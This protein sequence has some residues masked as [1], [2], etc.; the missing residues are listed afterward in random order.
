MKSHLPTPQDKEDSILKRDIKGI[1]SLVLM[2]LLLLS[3]WNFDGDPTRRHWLGLAGYALGGLLHA[4]LGVGS[5]MVVFY[6]GW[7]GVSFLS[8]FPYPATVLKRLAFGLFLLSFC[9]IANVIEATFPGLTELFG[10]PYSSSTLRGMIVQNSSHYYL[11]GVVC[12]WVYY[13]APFF[14][15][16]LLLNKLGTLLVFLTT[17]LASVLFLADARVTDVTTWLKEKCRRSP[18]PELAKEPEVLPKNPAS[19]PKE[20]F[21]TPPHVETSSAL[22]E[23]LGIRNE[24]KLKARPVSSEPR[25]KEESSSSQSPLTLPGLQVRLPEPQMQPELLFGHL[26]ME[27]AR[28][29]GETAAVALQEPAKK[30][31]APLKTKP[32]C[33]PP[34]QL[35][36]GDYAHYRLPPLSLL[37]EPTKVDQTLLKKGLKRQADRLEETLL[38]F[39]IEAKVGD[40]HCGPT[41]TSF[42]VHP[43]VGVKVQRIK[44]LEHDIALNLEAR[45]LRLI[46]P[47][48]GKA[49][50]GIEVPNAQPQEVG[51]KDILSSYQKGSQRYRIPVLLGKSVHGDYVMNDLTR[52][53]HCIIAGTTG[54]GKSVCI[55]TIVMTVLMMAKPD[56]IRLLMVDPKK[57]EL[58]AYSSLPHMLAPVITEA[59]EACAALNWLTKEMELRYELL[60]QLGTRNIEAFNNR[61]VDAEREAALSEVLGQKIPARM[62]YFLVIIDELADLMMVSSQDIETPIARLAQMARAVGIHL[63][64]AT[65][66]PSREVITGLIKANFP[67]R[68]SFKVSS[69]INSQIVLDDVG[70]ETLLGNGDMLF[71]PPS[72]SHLIRAQGPYVRDE[73]INQ[74]IRFICAQSPVN[75][76]TTSFVALHLGRSGGEGAAEEA[77]DSLYEEAYEL[78]MNTGNASTTFLQ[79]KLKIGYARAAS[80]MDQLESHHIVGPADGSK[81]RKVV[82]RTKADSQRDP[83]EE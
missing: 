77:L 73:D 62:P 26:P 55:N 64:V 30:P 57:V 21:N 58:T 5:Y 19:P 1:F 52:M 3:L 9:M 50:V 45:S 44:A 28:E 24:P 56:E 48:P 74:V 53:P 18:S 35:P 81:V 59:D 20:D 38:S 39:G 11:G 67:T 34:S 68:I 37:T 36:Q 15:L 70:A 13:E 22:N 72:S 33:P 31:P 71:L 60:K 75:Y 42:E 51:F 2:V 54:S 29:V 16:S 40:I 25:I 32:V 8:G 10:R 14:N 46:A 17:G 82:G 69:R 7:I 41:I 6:L 23:F 12:H 78:V 27:P 79:R 83:E 63:I 49:A 66:R 61:T 65:Q 80:I 47:I 76:V 4:S 43:A